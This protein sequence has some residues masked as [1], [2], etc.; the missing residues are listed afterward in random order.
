MILNESVPQI[1]IGNQFNSQVPK[2]TLKHQNTPNMHKTRMI[3][4]PTWQGWCETALFERLAQQALQCRASPCLPP[5]FFFLK[6][7][8]PHIMYDLYPSF[9]VDIT[10]VCA[11]IST[12]HSR[13]QIIVSDQHITSKLGRCK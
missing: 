12:E 8:M 11:N 10:S 6:R 4:W 1:F 9:E 2:Q 3:L 7:I 13:A 5:A